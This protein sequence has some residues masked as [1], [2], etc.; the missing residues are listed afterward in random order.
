MKICFIIMF[1]FAMFSYH[2][3]EAARKVYVTAR[4]ASDIR[5][6]AY[7]ILIGESQRQRIL[8]AQCISDNVEEDLNLAQCECNNKMEALHCAEKIGPK[9]GITPELYG[10]KLGEKCGIDLIKRVR[11]NFPSL[12]F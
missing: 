1:F 8:L 2:P 5:K 10:K 6:T 12:N 7:L 4:C 3:A 11:I 9:I